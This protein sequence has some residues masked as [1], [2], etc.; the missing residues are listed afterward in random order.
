M[1]ALLFMIV[2]TIHQ[3]SA[4][5][6]VK[7]GWGNN[8]FNNWKTLVDILVTVNI[9][10]KLSGLYAGIISAVILDTM[11]TGYIFSKENICKNW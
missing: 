1:H 2:K 10:S 4:V 9:E 5:S 7:S 6:T 8:D 3:A 11:V